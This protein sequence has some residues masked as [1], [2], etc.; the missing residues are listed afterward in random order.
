L[1]STIHENVK[2]SDGA[3]F[4]FF[5]SDGQR[6]G[7]LT[8]DQVKVVPISGGT[9]VVVADVAQPVAATWIGEHI[10]VTVEQGRRVSRVRAVAGE[11][12][13]EMAAKVVG[14]YF[15]QVLPD[16]QFALMTRRTGSYS[17]DYAEIMRVSLETGQGEVL[18]K[19]GYDA[20]YVASGHLLFGR[21][22]SLHAVAFDLSA[23]QVR[24]ESIVIASDVAMESLFR[25][26]HF[27]ASD[28][29]L[30]A[31]V[32]GGERARGRLAWV[33][34]TGSTTLL[35]TP[36]LVYGVVD[37][38]D[39]G[40]R[41]AAHVADVTDYILV[42]QIGSS[43]FSPLRLTEHVGFP[44]WH[45]DNRTLSF[46][47]W[48]SQETR[49]ILMRAPDSGGAPDEVLSA[50]RYVSP[51]DWLRKGDVLAVNLIDGPSAFFDVAHR[52]DRRIDVPGLMPRWSPDEQYF[53]F[54][55]SEAGRFEVFIRSYPDGRVERRLSLDGGVE[56]QWC[57]CGRVFYRKGNQW[58]ASTVR[59]SPQLA[60]GPPTRA[61][62]TDFI[63]TSGM[64]YDISPDGERLL[65]VKRTEPDIRDR[66]HIIADWTALLRNSSK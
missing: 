56:P 55:R 57:A 18:I 2:G 46:S 54:A 21:A 50:G 51:E 45:P 13:V 64:S 24:G 5:S 17:G 4:A 1:S 66:I 53:A 9:P 23:P 63:D 35:P 20:R 38:S 14:G 34:T 7:F 40:T 8:D 44:L 30:I 41:V 29:G 27:A 39:D 10:F 37:L 11:R 48:Q 52:S 58:F 22:G 28:N 36:P 60:P 43:Q 33:D 42:H 31:F 32:P 19:G 15:S 47:A 3:I 16:G 59:T 65:V 26:A 6:L 49:R 61:F 12:P 25:Q 62:Q